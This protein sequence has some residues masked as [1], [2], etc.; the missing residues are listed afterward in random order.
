MTLSGPLRL[1]AEMGG[2]RA[3]KTLMLRILET[4]RRGECAVLCSL[5]S[6]SG[7]TPRGP[8]AKMAVFRDGSIAGTIGGGMLEYRAIQDG[9]R[10]L[11]GEAMLVRDY[12]LDGGP[13]DMICG[14]GVRV[15]FQRLEGQDLL[16]TE[17]ALSLLEEP[18]DA[19]LVTRL[20]EDAAETGIYDRENGLRFL[21]G[22]DEVRVLSLCRRRAAF[23]DGLYVEPLNRAG[24][25]YVFGGGHV[26]QALVPLLRRIGFS[27][28]VCENR[29]EFARK[30]LFP[31][32]ERVELMDFS[33][34]TERFSVTGD[35]CLII[36]T[37]GHRDDYTV[38]LR[39]LETDAGYV[40]VIGSR[41][42]AA[43][44]FERLEQD[45]WSVQDRNR[46]HTPIGLPIG[47][48]T[49]EEIAV[50]IAAELIAHRSQRG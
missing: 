46:V 28:V 7:S 42:K 45:G 39:A 20:L 27:A 36:M 10:L 38:L 12:E 26:S 44:T 48:E 9:M 11:D 14:G 47:A 22:L 19:W 2:V 33:Q 37:R 24:R 3:V 23:T 49:P 4:L 30:E 34:F 5:L 6:S 8:G 32:A 15:L 21:S 1:T 25:V 17:T 18:C 43:V 35:D 41:R 29:A 13:L 40:G 31:D 16:W 50:S